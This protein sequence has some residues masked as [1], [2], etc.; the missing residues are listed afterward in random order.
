M[1]TQPPS[2]RNS[3]LIILF[4]IMYDAKNLKTQ[5]MLAKSALPRIC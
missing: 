2:I 4:D 3:F 1:I 5:N